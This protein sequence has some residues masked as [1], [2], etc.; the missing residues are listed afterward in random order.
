MKT[1][2][3]LIAAGLLVAV[4]CSDGSTGAARSAA[5]SA[6][7]TR[8]GGTVTVAAEQFPAT[9]N[10]KLQALAWTNRTAGVALARGFALT[11]DFGYQPSLFDGD[12]SVP[13]TSPFTVSCKILP[14]ARWSDGVDLTADDFKFTVDVMNDPKNKVVSREGYNKIQSFVVKGP[15]AFDLVFTEP[16][17]A[18][19]DLWTTAGAATL[20][21]HV[22]EGKDFNTVWN[23]C[24]CDPVTRKPV[25]SGPFLVESF[26]P[27]TGPLV[28]AR[29]EGY[30]GKRPKLD[31]IVFKP[32]TDT[33]AEVNA[34]GAGEVNVIFPAP[35]VG[36]RE[37]IAAI[38]DAVYE[39]A[40]GTTWEHF[41]MLTTKPGLEDVEVRKAIA[42]AMPRKQL[43]DRLV[44]PT[45]D[46]AAVLNNVMYMATQRDYQ[47]HWGIYPEA[48]DP[49]AAAQILERAGY[50]KGDDGVYAKGD[51]ADKVRLDFTIGVNSG[52]RT[53]ELAEQIIAD[54]LGKAGIRLTLAN[55]PNLLRGDKR[56]AGD[57]QT[58][59][60][61]WTGAPDPFG[62]GTIWR[63]DTI[64]TREEPSLGANFTR[65][66]NQKVTDL[67][68]E[69]DRE[70]DPRKRAGL[71][72]QADDVM[73]REGVSS[74]PL[75]QR[76]APLAYS[77]SLVGLK[78]NA[79]ADSFTWNVEEWAL[80]P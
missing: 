18:W 51:G 29:N 46:R 73:A 60:F 47:P 37:K 39:T 42:T 71:Y 76:P 45:D 5:E 59:I 58:I 67:I 23:D 62:G 57:Y 43:V 22:L 44:K 65:L 66:R 7:P 50:R 4:A 2:G 75:F 6:P 14:Q 26:T 56:L 31:K 64:P 17:P 9:L 10:T 69:A 8:D 63:A 40:L 30:W 3:C 21:K 11:P 13:T 20:P 12:C 32:I 35:Q 49:A 53:R 38:P 48:G 19:R 61:A 33:D 16:K 80:R 15:K 1:P 54:Q 27:G 78:V 24:I 36:L 77:S 55:D 72:N 52:D 25:G 74:I 70:L 34:F 68:K 28:L 79:T 41:D